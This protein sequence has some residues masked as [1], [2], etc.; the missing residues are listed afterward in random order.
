MKLYGIE[1]SE[2]VLV[3]IDAD[4][5]A[6]W[7]TPKDGEAALVAGCRSD[8][9]ELRDSIDNYLSENPDQGEDDDE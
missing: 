6:L 2:G 8:L 1:N 4:A 3:Y 5:D 9:E 7:V